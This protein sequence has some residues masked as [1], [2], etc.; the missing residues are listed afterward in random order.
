VVFKLA[1]EFNSLACVRHSSN[2]RTRGDGGYLAFL[3][4]PEERLDTVS[5]ESK[6]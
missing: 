5:E 3:V 4:V 1:D 2:N 6:F